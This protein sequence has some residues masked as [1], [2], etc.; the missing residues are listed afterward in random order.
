M[1]R[2]ICGVLF[3]LLLMPLASAAD[4]TGKWSGSLEG[5]DPNGQAVLIPAHADLRQQG[6]S[7]PGKVWKEIEHQFSVE[8]GKIEGNRITFEFKAPGGSEDAEPLVHS[9]RLTVVSED[10]LQGDLDVAMDGGKMPGKLKFT[11]EK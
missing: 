8:K 1:R 4:V 5:K 3:V 11:R 6:D 9:V 2:L 7:V 10:Q